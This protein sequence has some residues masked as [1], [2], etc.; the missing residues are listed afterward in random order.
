MQANFKA[1]VGQQVAS[2]LCPDGKLRTNGI[3]KAVRKLDTDA[4][5]CYLVKFKGDS[6]LHHV[7][8][9]DLTV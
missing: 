4:E 2:G 1:K 3:V 5:E 8:H 6:T 9:K 7:N